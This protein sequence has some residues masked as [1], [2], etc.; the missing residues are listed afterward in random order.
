MLLHHP[1]K[2][3]ARRAEERIPSNIYLCLPINMSQRFEK[4]RN[5]KKSYFGP[6]ERQ[7]RINKNN[8]STNG[9][10]EQHG[11]SFFSALHALHCEIIFV[12]LFRGFIMCKSCA[13]GK[14]F[15]HLTVFRFSPRLSCGNSKF[16]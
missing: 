15:I 2:M 14:K 8:N 1:N 10:S 16:G 5:E 6:E 12:F 4:L 13:G 9:F 11:K 3:Q 7:W